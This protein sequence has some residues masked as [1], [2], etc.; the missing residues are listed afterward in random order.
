[1]ASRR[2]SAVCRRPGKFLEGLVAAL[3]AYAEAVAVGTPQNKLP[4]LPEQ[5]AHIWGDFR[6]LRMT[7]LSGMAGQQITWAEINAYSDAHP[8]G[9]CFWQKCLIRRVDD[10][11]EI[12][13][14]GGS[15]TQKP[16]SVAD[17]RATLRA[18]AKARKNGKRVEGSTS[19]T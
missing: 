5:L 6:Q 11:Y 14:Q 1:M 3:I 12:A 2:G 4:A 15:K 19:P 16:T 8:A 10:A 9:L 13:R 17:M 18:A 7:K